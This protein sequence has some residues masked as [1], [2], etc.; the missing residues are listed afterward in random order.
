MFHGP[1]SVQTRRWMCRHTFPPLRLMHTHARR[2]QR[3]PAIQCERPTPNLVHL[4][5]AAPLLCAAASSV[6]VKVA[7]AVRGRL[8]HGASQTRACACSKVSA[9]SAAEHWRSV[10][11]HCTCRRS[12]AQL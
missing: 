2:L 7:V 4:P 8:A 6:Q 12:R 1:K 3:Q 10:E 11:G 9:G 5:V